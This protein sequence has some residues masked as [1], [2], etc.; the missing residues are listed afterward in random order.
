M[1]SVEAED[2]RYLHRELMSLQQDHTRHSNRIKGLLSEQGVRLAVGQHFLHELD[3]VRLWDGHPLPPGLRARVEREYAGLQFVHQHI[4][5]L[6]AERTALLR[7]STDPSVDMVR[8]LMRLRSLGD[9]SAWVFVMEFFAWRDFHNRREVG[10]L[11]GL[12]ATPFDSG[13]LSHDQGISKAG[14]SPI[15]AM[16]IEI[17]WCWLRYQ[18]DSDLSHWFNQRFGKGGKRLRK[19]GIVALARKLL[20]ALWGYLDSGEIPAGAQL[21]PSVT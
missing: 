5:E 13:N 20:I 6:E 9:H 1:P 3:A 17:A 18:P 16:A 8:R 14:N 11:A 15:R 21:K 10:G 19:I 12:A 7:T 4:L 2:A